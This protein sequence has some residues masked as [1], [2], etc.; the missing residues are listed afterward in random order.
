M[1]P[2]WTPVVLALVA[3]AGC[4]GGL[5]RPVDPS[6]P[7]PTA[8]R[9]PIVEQHTRGLAPNS[10]GTVTAPVGA[11]TLEREPTPPAGEVPDPVLEKIHEEL[12]EQA[13]EVR[14]QQ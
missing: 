12:E 7:A 11:G 14:G 9:P 1:D 2:R 4:T 13:D 10:P 6:A 5:P 8:E 3:L